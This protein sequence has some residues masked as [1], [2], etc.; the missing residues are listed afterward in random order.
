MAKD[1]AKKVVADEKANASKRIADLFNSAFG[2]V[3]DSQLTFK[4]P[5]DTSGAKFDFTLVLATAK[6]DKT[7]PPEKFARGY[8]GNKP[9]PQSN[10]EATV[11]YT[12]PNREKGVGKFAYIMFKNF[13]WN[14]LTKANQRRIGSAVHNYVRENVFVQEKEAKAKAKAEAAKVTKASKE[15]KA[16]SKS[17]K[18][19]SKKVAVE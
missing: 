12:R 6:N 16:P 7:V 10:Y 19:S 17:A 2:E 9:V 11:T 13:H 14:A 4:L 8:K 18:S 3:K 5:K 1:K 15:Q